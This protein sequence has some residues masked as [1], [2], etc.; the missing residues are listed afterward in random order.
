MLKMKDICVYK[1]GVVKSG[2]VLTEDNFKDPESYDVLPDLN[3]IG[4]WGRT[5]WD[6]F[7]YALLMG[8]NVW[9]HI[10]AVQEANRKFDAGECRPAMTT[11]TA[12]TR[13]KFEEIVDRVFAAPTKA[14]SIEIIEFYSEY[15][16]EIL[17]GRGNKGKK[18]QNSIT[19]FNNLF[20]EE[21]TTVEADSD[22]LSE[23]KLDA[24]EEEQHELRTA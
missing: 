2:V 22:D 18:A 17:G 1:P 24:L 10:T 16:K 4:K 5:S 9:M 3:K 15:W 19:H 6:S 21:A 12:P 11:Y 8:H 7:S 20:Y 23:D 14:E 13:D